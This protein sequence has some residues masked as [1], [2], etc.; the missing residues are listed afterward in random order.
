MKA[1][2]TAINAYLE[3]IATRLPVSRRARTEAI[4]EL[5]SGL[6]DAAD[7]RRAAG[8][9]A[10]E[11]THAAIAEFGNP[12]DIAAELGGELA[13]TQARRLTLTLLASGPLIGLFWLLAALGSRFGFR[14]AAPWQWAGLTAGAHLAAHLCAAV[15]L[16]AACT[17]AVTLAVTRAPSRRTAVHSR[18]ISAA[19]ASS[20]LGIAA[21]DLAVLALL[22]SQWVD[23]P[24]RLDPLPVALAAVASLIRL[25]F[26]GRAAHSCARAAHPDRHT[27]IVGWRNWQGR[28]A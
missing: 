1:T 22:T 6:L 27:T 3:E 23:A 8:L 9:S 10:T 17:S 28:A 15:L 11:A 19:A 16:L 18:L 24:D 4:A 12:G 5:R 7:A 20:G 25:A 14:L 26:T 13:V 2:D 21:A